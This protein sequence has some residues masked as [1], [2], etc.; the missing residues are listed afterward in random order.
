MTR[1]VTSNI[2]GFK[3]VIKNIDTDNFVASE[4][5][6]QIEY[7]STLD[8]ALCFYDE[9][10]AESVLEGLNSQYPDCFSLIEL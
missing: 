5:K 9:Y 10:D 4:A 1:K 7:T 6:G 2:D 8:G 3:A